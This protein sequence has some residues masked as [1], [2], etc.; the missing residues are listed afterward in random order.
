MSIIGKWKVIV[1]SLKNEPWQSNQKKVMSFFND[2]PNVPGYLCLL[3]AYWGRGLIGGRWHG[4]EVYLSRHFNTIVAC[5]WNRELSI[6]G[7]SEE[8]ILRTAEEIGIKRTEKP[9]EIKDL[10]ENL[11]L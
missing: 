9:P 2:I 4:K 8:E 10:L 1:F 5:E 11:E 6:Y 7:F 3:T